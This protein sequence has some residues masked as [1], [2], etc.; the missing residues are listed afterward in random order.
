MHLA[1]LEVSTSSYN[2]QISYSIAF[3]F[4]LLEA[5]GATTKP[6]SGSWVANYQDEVS[7]PNQSDAD[8]DLAN[9]DGGDGEETSLENIFSGVE[10]VILNA[11]FNVI[12]Y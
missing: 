7:A 5:I 9:F 12:I 4:Q 8:D 11:E 6:G 10:K 2:N 1:A 3:F